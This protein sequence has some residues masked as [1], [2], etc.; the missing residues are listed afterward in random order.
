VDTEW[1]TGSTSGK[2]RAFPL[3]LLPTSN[4]RSFLIGYCGWT[5]ELPTHLQLLL[6][7]WKC[8]LLLLLYIINMFHCPTKTYRGGEWGIITLE[9]GSSSV[10]WTQISRYN[11]KTETESSLR[12]LCSKQKTGRWIMY[13][14]VIVTFIYYRHKPTNRTDIFVFSRKVSCVLVLSLTAL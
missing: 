9:T 13:R 12:M 11:L 14:I 3:A 10:G 5:E 4:S 2:N 7:L 8:V 1:V 6:K